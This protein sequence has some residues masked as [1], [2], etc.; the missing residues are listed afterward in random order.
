MWPSPRE[1]SSTAKQSGFKYILDSTKNYI[2]NRWPV[3]LNLSVF[4]FHFF[5]LSAYFSDLTT[6]HLLWGRQYITT[7]R[8]YFFPETQ[9]IAW[10][11]INIY[12]NVI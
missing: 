1:Y 12:V 10:H 4:M 11:F 8:A 3:I 9:I 6:G 2:Y 5:Q 7:K